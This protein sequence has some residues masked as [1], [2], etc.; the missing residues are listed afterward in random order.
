MFSGSKINSAAEINI[1]YFMLQGICES[2]HNVLCPSF[3]AG[4]QL[5]YSTKPSRLRTSLDGCHDPRHG[6][7][8]FGRFRSPIGL[9]IQAPLDG[10]LRVFEK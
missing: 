6:H 8:S 5:D 4:G 9:G 7:S 1:R 10:L 2:F 3:D